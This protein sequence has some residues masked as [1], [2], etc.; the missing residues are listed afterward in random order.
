M[1]VQ[2]SVMG[3]VGRIDFTTQNQFCGDARKHS[4]SDH[5]ASPAR[6]V[7]NQFL[8]RCSKS[9]DCCC[10]FISV[11][12]KVVSQPKRWLAPAVSKVGVPYAGS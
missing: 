9:D 4:R 7:I 8:C 6:A 3:A 2:L 11:V 1:K 10:S 5:A 12:T